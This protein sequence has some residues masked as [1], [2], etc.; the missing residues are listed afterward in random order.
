V[1]TRLA[2]QRPTRRP[3]GHDP[4]RGGFRALAELIAW[5]AV[6][7]ALWPQSV[8]LAIIAVLFL[9]V[10]PAIFTTPGDRPGGD[11]PVAAPGIVTILSVVAHL[12][13]ATAAAWVIWPGWLAVLV[14]A[15]CIGVL[16]TEQ[17][18]WSHLLSS[19]GSRPSAAGR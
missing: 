14:T 9:V 3:P 13:A 15:L 16:F 12:V 4:V 8:P 17:P 18:R 2:I 10:P 7:V 1:I 19:R 11:G 5:I 6:P